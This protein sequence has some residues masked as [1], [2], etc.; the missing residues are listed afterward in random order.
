[1]PL[2]LSAEERREVLREYGKLYN[3]HVLI[4]TGTNDGGT[5]WALRDDFDRIF[6]IELGKKQWSDAVQMFG[7]F[8]HIECL[9]GDSADVLPDVLARISEPA[10]VWL[11][12][13]HSG[14]G[15]A[16]GETLST[17]IREELQTLFA[18]GRHHVIIVDDARIFGG[19]PEHDM[20]DHYADYP[21]L[22]WV[23][24]LARSNGYIYDLRDDMIRLVYHG[25]FYAR[26]HL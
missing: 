24:E 12:G 2:Y 22:D 15:T 5:P 4:E 13:H 19:G 21:S 17:P 3:L 10:L 1:M 7:E 18:D 9:F 14:P 25:S 26:K 20:Y 23:E 8:P 6:T 11:D 16:H